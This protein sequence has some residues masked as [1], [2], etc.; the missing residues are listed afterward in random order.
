MT[1]DEFFGAV[2]RSKPEKREQLA[3]ELLPELDEDER[4][5]AESVV[6][7]F[8]SVSDGIYKINA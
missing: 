7:D 6:G 1:I 3:R 8:I 2:K 4:V 5:L